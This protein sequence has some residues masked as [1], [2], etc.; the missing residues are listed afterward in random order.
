LGLQSFDNNLLKY[1]NRKHTGENGT[2]AINKIKQAGFSNIQIVKQK[3]IIIPDDIL[4]Q[5]LSEKELEAYKNSKTE[6]Q[7]ITVIGKKISIPNF[8][9][10]DSGCC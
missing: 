3:N 2:A 7:S 9:S 8:C 1:L 10:I 4:N 5:Y 6:I